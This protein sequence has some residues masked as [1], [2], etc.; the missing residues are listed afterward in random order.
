[1][2]FSSLALD[3]DSGFKGEIEFYFDESEHGIAL[4]DHRDVSV[5]MELPEQHSSC[6]AW[7]SE[8][9]NRP[10][11]PNQRLL[12]WNNARGR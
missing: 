6:R 5:A 12:T 8:S 10:P 2:T 9:M 11:I 7:L 4:V 3:V 1:M